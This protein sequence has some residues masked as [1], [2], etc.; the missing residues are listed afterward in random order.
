MTEAPRIDGYDILRELGRGA[1]GVVYL[2]RDRF[3]ERDVA[4][5]LVAESELTIDG[6]DRFL[7]EARAMA[8]LSHPNV[9]TVYRAGVI[10][11]APFLVMELLRGRS[12]DQVLEQDGPL[13]SQKLLSVAIE[14]ARGIAAAH[15]R[16]VVHRDI[17]PSNL[18]ETEEGTVKVL[19]F[20]IAKV[21][22]APTDVSPINSSGPEKIGANSVGASDVSAGRITALL[23]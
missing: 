15:A 2:A 22:S 12:L 11:G 1:M 19:D 4:I 10:D 23:P 5:K 7:R 17:K 21:A 8:R 20:G 16:G 14:A 18:F 3:L 13:S 9:V 6:V